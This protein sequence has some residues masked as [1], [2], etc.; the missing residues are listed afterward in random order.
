MAAVSF[1]PADP[2]CP[3]GKNYFGGG[4]PITSVG[5][6][7]SHNHLVRDYARGRPSRAKTLGHAVSIVGGLVIGESAVNAGIVGSLTLMVVALAALASYATPKLYEAA[8]AMRLVLL[9]LGGFLG[10]WGVRLLLC[11][12]VEC[13]RKEPLWGA[14]Y[15]AA[16]PFRLSAMRDCWFVPVG[17]HYPSG[18]QGCRI[19]LVR[20]KGQVENHDGAAA[21]PSA[22]G[23]LYCIA[24]MSRPI[25]MLS[26]NSAVLGGNNAV[27]NTVSAGIGLLLSLISAIPVFWL[28]SRYP[29]LNILDVASGAMGRVGLLVP[30]L[31]LLYFVLMGCYYVSFF[32]SVYWKCNGSKNACVADCTGRNCRVL[33]WGKARA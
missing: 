31:Y 26:L 33:L 10:M 17:R 2:G 21:I 11:G 12:S 20:M 4:D 32:C 8:C 18:R 22:P 7:F 25:V 28:C 24:F 29:A 5:R 16:F 30:I 14:V 9:V 6:I 27:D 13:L 1:H 15:R 23:Q 19:C 3:S